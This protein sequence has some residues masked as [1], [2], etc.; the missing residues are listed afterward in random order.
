MDKVNI[1]EVSGNWEKR[2][3]SCDTWFDASGQNWTGFVHTTDEVV[4][5][6]E[7]KIE[8]EVAGKHIIPK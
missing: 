4:I 8:F 6:L 5:V 2:G 7:G 3:F 1:K